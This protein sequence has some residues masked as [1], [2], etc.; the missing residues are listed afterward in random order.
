MPPSVRLRAGRDVDR[1][2]E[3]VRLQLR[4]EVVEHDAGLDRD[5]AALGVDS[6]TRAQML[7]GVDHQRRADRSGRTGWCRRRAAAP[8]R[9]QLAR[10]LERRR[11]VAIGRSGTS[12]PT[13]MIW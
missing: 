3:A 4:V 12:T 1:E 2:P 7:A 10:D 9:F 5:G 6:A 8:A 13:G 11:D